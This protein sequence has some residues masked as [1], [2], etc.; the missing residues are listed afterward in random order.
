MEPLKAYL[1]LFLHRG[2]QCNSMRQRRRALLNRPSRQAFRDNRL[3]SNHCWTGRS[4]GS[5]A[6]GGYALARY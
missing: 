4:W 2:L 5:C 1:T 3:R 6:H